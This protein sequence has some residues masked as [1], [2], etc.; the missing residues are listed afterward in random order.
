MKNI[1]LAFVLVL[2]SYS[3][4]VLA[5]DD[6]NETTGPD[7]TVTGSSSSS[8]ST[9]VVEEDATAPVAAPVTIDMSNFKASDF[10]FSPEK[11]RSVKMLNG[12]VIPDFSALPAN[13]RNFMIERADN[14]DDR[15]LMQKLQGEH[16]EVSPSTHGFHLDLK[17]SKPFDDLVQAYKN[18]PLK[19]KIKRIKAIQNPITGEKIKGSKG[20]GFE[21]SIP[22]TGM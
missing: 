15:R 13:F 17:S 11:A 19:F 5:A 1:V 20:W 3:T 12:L 22:L 18:R 6:D 8:D 9:A 10:S 2:T 16:D 14:D 7:V 4:L 21:I